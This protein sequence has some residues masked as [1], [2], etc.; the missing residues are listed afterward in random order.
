MLSIQIDT[1]SATEEIRRQFSRLTDSQAKSAIVSALNETAVYGRKRIVKA[2]Q[3]HYNDTAFTVRGLNN[4]LSIKRAN[5]GRLEATI[6]ITGKKIPLRYFSPRQ[7]GT[8]QNAQLSVAIFKGKRKVIKSAF[9]LPGNAFANKKLI[10]SRGKYGGNKFNPRH[11]RV[12]PYPQ[13]DFPATQL[14]GISIPQTFRNEKQSTVE[15]V[16]DDLRREY[17]KRLTRI[18]DAHL[19]SKFKSNLR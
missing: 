6:F 4:S 7:T 5:S 8:G 1:R 14:V 19:Q 11:H 17:P 18:M 16:R 3:A 13:S 2:I 10:F 12:K 9:Y 15:E